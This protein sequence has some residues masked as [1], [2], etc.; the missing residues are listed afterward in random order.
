MLTFPPRYRITNRLDSA[1]NTYRLFK[2]LVSETGEMTNQEFIN[3]QIQACNLALVQMQTPVDVLITPLK[4]YINQGSV[5]DRPVL[6][7]DGSTM[8]YTESRGLES[9]VYVTRKDGD[10]WGTP[11]DITS[12]AAMG[13][14]CYTTSLNSDGTE[15]YL[16]KKDNY[17]GNIYVTT[18]KNGN[19]TEIISLN[20]NINTK[21]YE[22]HAAISSDGKTTYIQ[23]VRGTGGA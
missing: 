19:W 2:T 20:K 8:A 5:N 11:I 16:F 1:L 15:L 23:P 9:V 21:Y 12:Q 10:S 7:Y 3:Q 14:D 6:S 4:E 18:F 13:T 17:D 22:S